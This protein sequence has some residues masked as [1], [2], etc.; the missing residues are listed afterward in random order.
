MMINNSNDDTEKISTDSGEDE[1]EQIKDDNKE[2]IEIEEKV[3]SLS[4]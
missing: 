3:R 2:V 4:I 1:S